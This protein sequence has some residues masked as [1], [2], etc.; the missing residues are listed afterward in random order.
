M[1]S[2]TARPIGPSGRWLRTFMF[3]AALAP[4]LISADAFS[5]LPRKEAPAIPLPEPRFESGVSVEEA[6]KK[7]RSVRKYDGR[8]L[9]LV[10][11]SQLLWAAQ[12]I[13]HDRFKRT[14]PSGGALYPLELYVVA[15]NVD[16]LAP[17]IYRYLPAD[18]AITKTQD[19]DKRPELTGATLRQNYIG[20]AAACFVFCA[21]YERITKKYGD[22]GV[23]YTFME[24]GHAA[25]NVYLQGAALGIDTVVVGAFND[26]E[27]KAV[28]TLENDEEP[29]YI[30]PLGRKAGR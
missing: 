24:A 3:A 6:L 25:Q 22:R 19:G 21:V 29:L 27:V 4:L 23:R 2:N 15:G 7:R 11:I 16:G 13:T 5:G 14:A 9:S 18:H 17:G 28:V 12:G 8:A 26:D 10:E 30:M 20:D 1:I